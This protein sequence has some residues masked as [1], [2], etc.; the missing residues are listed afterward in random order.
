MDE[1]ITEITRRLQR[2]RLASKRF[3]RKGE[4]SAHKHLESTSEFAQEL[5]AH[6][7]ILV[8]KQERILKR[9]YK[10]FFT[11]LT[12]QGYTLADI[13]AA[14]SKKVATVALLGALTIATP[15]TLSGVTPPIRAP[16]NQ[17][18]YDES[19]TLIPIRTLAE[20]TPD[21]ARVELIK[22]LPTLTHNLTSGEGG[23]VQQLLTKIIGVPVLAQLDG[24][25]LNVTYG[26]IGAEQHLFR[27]PGDS[28]AEHAGSTGNQMRVLG[29]GIAPGLGAWGYFAVRKAYLTKQDS[30]R[31]TWYIAAQ[32]FLSP[33]W[34]E[35]TNELYTWF[36]YRKVI[37]IDPTTQ[38]AVVA[39]IADAGP[40]DWTGKKFGGS[41]ELMDYMKLEDGAAKR[42]VIVLFVDDPKN[43][44]PLG[45]IPIAPKEEGRA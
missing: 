8:D 32:T 25:R 4:K 18:H 38:K 29:R 6:L 40:A 13:R 10:E 31:E 22:I 2:L 27:Y 24:N 1:S 12:S 26:L 20:A 9:T 36:Q 14:L 34:N 42:G 37:V 3:F 19:R 45:P 16:P 23:T 28:L 30:E 35:R 41:P 15:M 43:T 21:E 7:D 44:V 33:E 17:T 39:V 5:L 11:Y